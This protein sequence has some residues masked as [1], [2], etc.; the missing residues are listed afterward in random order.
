MSSIN[1]VTSTTNTLHTNYD[2]SKFLLGFNSFTSGDVVASG[3]DVELKQ[4]MIMGRVA[5]TG[6]LTPLDASA[7]DG[8]QY[9]VGMAIIDDT[10]ADGNTKTITIVNKGRVDYDTVNFSTADTLEST[11][12]P[13]DNKRQI[14]DLIADLGIIMEESDELTEYDNS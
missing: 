4:G 13:A 12:G 5:A 11:V 3:S 10:V 7:T 14:R 9:P 2:L 8:S 6:N 1:E